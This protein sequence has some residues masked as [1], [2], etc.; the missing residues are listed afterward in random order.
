VVITTEMLSGGKE[1]R[2]QLQQMFGLV[3]F[4]SDGYLQNPHAL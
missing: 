1:T 4:E 3:S 2:K